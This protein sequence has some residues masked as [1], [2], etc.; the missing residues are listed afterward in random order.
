MLHHTSYIGYWLLCTRPNVCRKYSNFIMYPAYSIT[1]NNKVHSSS[2]KYIISQ[3]HYMVS[4]ELTSLCSLVFS[5]SIL[6]CVCVCVCV[7]CA[8]V[9]VCVCRSNGHC[10]CT[11]VWCLCL[12]EQGSNEHLQVLDAPT[13]GCTECSGTLNDPWSKLV[14]NEK[15]S[16]QNRLVTQ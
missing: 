2:L 7:C 11:G 15:Q 1:F 13:S 16:S 6:V 12:Q 8:R 4:C 9:C 14:L 3:M 5:A 10:S